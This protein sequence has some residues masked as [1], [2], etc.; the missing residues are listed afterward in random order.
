MK[1]MKINKIAIIGLGFN[2]LVVGCA[3]NN[4]V[5]PATVDGKHCSAEYASQYND[6]VLELNMLSIKLSYK[7]NENSEEILRQLKRSSKVCQVIMKNYKNVVCTGEV[8]YEEKEV[9][10]KDFEDQCDKVD[11]LLTKFENK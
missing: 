1:N 8:D 7:S 9:S 10:T 11:S 5:P 6:V 2:L 4:S 3:P